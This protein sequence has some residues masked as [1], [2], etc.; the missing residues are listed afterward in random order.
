MYGEVKMLNPKE[1]EK[2]EG[3]CK[4]VYKTKDGTRIEKTFDS[5]FLASKLV[6]KLQR[7]KTCKLISYSGFQL[8][9]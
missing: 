6:Y 1:P 8:G 7:S 3:S 9:A 5:P 4:V 2:H